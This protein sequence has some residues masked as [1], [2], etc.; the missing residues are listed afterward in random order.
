MNHQYMVINYL[1]IQKPVDDYNK[2]MGRVDRFDQMLKTYL[3]VKGNNKSLVS[4]A[5]AGL[6][7]VGPEAYLILGPSVVKR[8]QTWE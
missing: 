4:E 5:G 3:P 8:I 6:G 2:S 1:E 7:F